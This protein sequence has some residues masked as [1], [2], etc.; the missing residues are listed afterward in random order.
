[1]TG[2]VRPGNI[3]LLGFPVADP[4]DGQV[5]FEC[6]GSSHLVRGENDPAPELGW[7]VT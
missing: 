4:F 1:M 5:L 3:R 6:R 7:A 2:T